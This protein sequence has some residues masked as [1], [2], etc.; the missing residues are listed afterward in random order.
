MQTAWDREYATGRYRGES[1]VAFV[2]DIL[3]AAGGLTATSPGLYIG[4]GNGRNYL[5]LTDAGL[6]L[7]G[8][9]ISAAALSQLAAARPQRSYRL[10][11]GTLADL[12]AEQR[13]PVVIGIQVFQHGDRDAAHAHL[14]AAAARVEPG[15]LLAIRVNATD[16]DLGHDHDPLDTGPDGGFSIT[17]RNG[18]KTGL[19]VHFYTD[20]EL[21]ALL[22]ES[23][24]PV[25]A[26]RLHSTRRPPPKTGQW[27]QWEAIWQRANTPLSNPGRG[28]SG[29]TQSRN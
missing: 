15:G 13:F 14:A 8:L 22:G 19:A 27:S 4:C 24:A 2:D 21:T 18:P 16:T 3:A 1:P 28:S 17:Y 25:L 9:D 12:P 29:N 6:D 11:H 20:T 26:P 5:P 7:I 23:F 10:V